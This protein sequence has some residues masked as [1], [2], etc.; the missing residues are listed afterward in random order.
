LTAGA[1]GET[2]GREAGLAA[3]TTERRDMLFHVTHRH[4]EATCPYNNDEVRE[5]TFGRVVPAI[6]DAG[7]RLIGAWTDPASHQMFFV[8]EAERF[9]DLQQALEPIIDQGT[10]DIRPVREF[11]PAVEELRQRRS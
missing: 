10:A 8:L 5:A 1:I 3:S 11:A 9:E 4:T 7:V 2:V 6:G